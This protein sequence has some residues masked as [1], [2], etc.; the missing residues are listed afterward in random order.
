M[1]AASVNFDT[2]LLAT[3]GRNTGIEV[4]EELVAA[5]GA[6]KRP[7]VLVR[8]NDYEYRSTIAPMGGRFLIPFSADKRAETGLAAGDPI[9]VVLVHDDAPRSVEVPEDLAAAL[10]GAGA[11]AAFDALSPSKRKAHVTSVESAKAAPTRER[12]I[13]AVLAAL[14]G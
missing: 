1:A 6:G 13:A 7:P 4:P 14:A 2:E 12:R 11:R 3:G 10:A 9:R 8:V 5:L